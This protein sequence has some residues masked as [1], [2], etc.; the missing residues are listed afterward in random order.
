MQ[1][2]GKLNPID[3]RNLCEEA[4]FNIFRPCVSR[5]KLKDRLKKEGATAS[6]VPPTI[7]GNQCCGA[8][9][10]VDLV[11]LCS[12]FVQDAES[13]PEFSDSLL[14]QRIPVRG[15]APRGRLHSPPAISCGTGF[16]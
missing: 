6:Q 1:Q 16:S 3:G 7:L 8:V 11:H 4:F 12:S 13:A 15:H 2:G 10:L 9:L 5:G 14:F